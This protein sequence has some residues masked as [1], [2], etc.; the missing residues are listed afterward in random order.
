VGRAICRDRA[1]CRED[2]SRPR[3]APLDHRGQARS[4]QPHSLRKAATV[5]RRSQVSD[6]Q[7]K[8][9]REELFHPEVDKAL[10]R[11]HAGRERLIAKRP[12]VGPIRR[13][14]MNSMFYLPIAAVL[15]AFSVWYLLEPKIEDMPV[16]GGEVALVNA[17]PFDAEPGTIAITVGSHEVY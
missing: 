8:I 7:I 11:E 12:P 1:R 13:L 4:G 15:G 14:L 16:V 9:A 5:G 6:Q 2:G 3:A 17:E 10:A